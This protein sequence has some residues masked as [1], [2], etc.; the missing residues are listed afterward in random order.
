MDLSLAHSLHDALRGDRTVFAYSGSF[1]DDR[2]GQLVTLGEAVSEGPHAVRGRLAFIMVEAYQNIVRHRAGLPQ[3]QAH[4]AGRSLF[5][6]R[7]ADAGQQVVTVNP[8]RQDQ[9]PGLQAALE[10]LNGM[11]PAGLKGLLIEGL[12]KE[13]A[14]QRRGA[15]LGLIEMARRSG[16]DLGGGFRDLS[17]AHALFMLSVRTG[18]APP[19]SEALERADGMHR[20][21]MEHGI[22]LLYAGALPTGVR[23]ALRQMIQD[24]GDGP[25]DGRG[26]VFREAL[27]L[28]SADDGGDA[29]WLIIL[30]GKDG[31]ETLTVG[32]TIPPGASF[33]VLAR[34]EQAAAGGVSVFSEGNG[35]RFVAFRA[36]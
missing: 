22:T 9:V 16:A 35:N 18:N 36:L 8:V 25:P 1:H 29:R 2:T 4:G 3:E 32:R 33:P 28:L 20:T 7:C 11:D 13:H 34:P 27:A 17:E 31:R 24:E 14:E 30:A 19:H 21:V 5:L 15:G 23:G 26:G 12:E 10:R 6:L